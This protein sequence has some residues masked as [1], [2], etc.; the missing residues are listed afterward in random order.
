MMTEPP[1]IPELPA[2]EYR[3]HPWSWLFVALQHLKQFILP[4]LV[5]LIAR[6]GDGHAL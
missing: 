4:L 1:P 3:L 2:R 6:R 5:L